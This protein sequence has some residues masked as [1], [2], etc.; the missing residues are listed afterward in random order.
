MSDAPKYQLSDEDRELANRLNAAE[1]VVWREKAK[2]IGDHLTRASD[3]LP[4]TA[5]YQ[6]CAYAL[7]LG[8]STARMYVRLETAFGAVLDEFRT[9]DGDEIASPFQLRQI[10]A[11][12]KKRNLSPDEA[13]IRRIRESDNYGGQVAPPDVIAAQTRG[14]REAVPPELR[15]LKSAARSLSTYL[16]HCERKP[17]RLNVEAWVKWIEKRIGEM[18]HEA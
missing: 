8:I 15:A 4:L 7:R 18:T 3:A 16:R 1:G 12:A 10:Y 2:Y 6:S 5:I 13:L 9:P 11:E 17:D 14:Q